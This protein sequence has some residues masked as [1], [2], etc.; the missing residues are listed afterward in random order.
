M[1]DRPIGFLDS[2]IGGVPY[3]LAARRA[4]PSHRYVYYADNRHFPYG[5][6]PVAEVR[7]TVV[8]AVTKLIETVD[9]A[10]IVVACNT[11]SVV[12]LDE[13]RS[14]FALPFVG[15]VPAIKPAAEVVRAKRI[16]VL[17]TSR[18]VRDP[19]VSD[20]IR[21]FAGSSLVE[22]VPAD[23]LVRLIEDRFGTIDE[24]EL[25]EAVREPIERLLESGVDAI[26]LGCTHFVH[27]RTI[28]ETMA[29][30]T[31]S[32][33]DSVDG[34]VRQMLRLAGPGVPG[35]PP[36][37]PRL[38]LSDPSPAGASYRHLEAMYGFERMD[39]DIRAGVDG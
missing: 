28:I 30:D 11:A 26:V 39:A 35:A 8:D 14:R 4:A 38:I 12:G 22:L 15:V 32:V 29:G 33:I 36:A 7:R 19:Y 2:G 23:S 31:V 17:A 6:R 3:L 1:S 24:A 25:R 5:D 21:R 20:L 13:L 34:V 37:N 18:T 10:L 27:V 9:P 16:G